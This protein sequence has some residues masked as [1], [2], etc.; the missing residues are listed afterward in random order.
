MTKNINLFLTACIKDLFQQ[1]IPQSGGATAIW[2]IDYDN[3]YAATEIGKLINC[4]GLDIPTL[5][6]CLQEVDVMTLLKAHKDF[7]VRITSLQENS[8]EISP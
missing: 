4:T 6:T 2:A 7:Q 8:I 5:T 1:F 3:I